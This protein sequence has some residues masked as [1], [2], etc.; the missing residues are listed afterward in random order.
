MGNRAEGQAAGTREEGDLKSR[1]RIICIRREPRIPRGISQNP[2]G[3]W[4]RADLADI[5]TFAPAVVW[6]E[7]LGLGF[8]LRSVVYRHILL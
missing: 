1:F 5:M 6:S 7:Q 3:N 2:P 8:A 4:K